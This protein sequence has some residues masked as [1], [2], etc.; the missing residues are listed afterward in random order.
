M[1]E[2]METR[3]GTSRELSLTG[4]EAAAW[5]VRCARTSVAYSFPMGPNSEVTETLQKLVDISEAP[6]LQVIYGES[7]KAAQSMQIASARLGVRSMICINSEGLLWATSEIHYGAC[8]RLPML[9]VCPSRALEPPTTVYSDHDDFI[10][11]RDMG[12]LMFYCSDPQDVFDTILQ[13]YRVIEHPSVMLPAMVAY[14][15]WEVSHATA[16]VRIP[17]QERIDDFLP[18]PDFIHPD[19]DY[20]AEDWKDRF[21]R[22]RLQDAFG[23][24]DFMELRHLQKK[25]EADSAALIEQV[26]DDYREAFGGDHVGLLESHRCDDAEI[27]ILTMGVIY[28]T[29][30]LVVDALRRNGTKIGC[31]KLRVFRPFPAAALHEAIRNARLVVTIERNCLSALYT[32]LRSAL[33]S[34]LAA[35]D[36]SRPPMVMGRVIGLGGAPIPVDHILHIV[37]EAMAALAAN[38]VDRELEWYPIRGVD[39]DPTRHVIGE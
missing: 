20:L 30:R 22:R 2:T 28:P 26:G 36:G 5:A 23:A 31:I 33:F 32:E 3:E 25:A 6:G 18:A 12:W 27:V 4:N 1:A 37:D 10:S 13:A 21:S 35:G 29:T 14:D 15:G 39:F 9:L 8:S 17:D 24:P 16:R 11:Q 38:R 19:K 7:E 34:S